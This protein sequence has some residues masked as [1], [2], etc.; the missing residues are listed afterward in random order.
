[1]VFLGKRHLHIPES[2]HIVDGLVG[3]LSSANSGSIKLEFANKPVAEIGIFSTDNLS[4]SGKK[5]IKV[6]LLEPG[7]FKVQ[8]DDLGL[9][10]KLRTATELAQKLTDNMLTL[11]LFRKGKEAIT[12]GEGLI[13]RFQD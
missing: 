5:R 3:L 11:S 13:L 4:N 1:M 12:L 8:D 7:L 10:D 2:D 6:D 9:F